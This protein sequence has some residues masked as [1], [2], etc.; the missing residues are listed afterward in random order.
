MKTS[1]FKKCDICGEY[2]ECEIHHVIGGTARQI[3]DKY[4]AVVSCCRTCHNKI[5]HRPA[6]YT[7]LRSETQKR[8]MKEQ[9][10]DL[11][12]WMEHFYKNYLEE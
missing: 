11:A 12:E 8:V 9:G 4:G 10:W 1:R 7:W 3:S 2:S 6:D 5:H